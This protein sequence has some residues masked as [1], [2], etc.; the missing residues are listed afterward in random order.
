MCLPL[1]WRVLSSEWAPG[2]DLVLWKNA[3]G[4]KDQHREGNTRKILSVYATDCCSNFGCHFHLSA[5][6]K[7]TAMAGDRGWQSGTLQ[8]EL[9]VQFLDDSKCS[10]LRQHLH[11][12]HSSR[13]NWFHTFRGFNISR[14][15]LV[16]P[17]EKGI[18]L[19]SDTG[20]CFNSCEI[21]HCLFPGARRL[22]HKRSKVKK[23][24]FLTNHFKTNR[25]FRVSKMLES[26][27]FM[28]IVPPYRFTVYAIGILLGYFLHLFKNRTLSD[29][30]LKLGWIAALGSL[31]ITIAICFRNITYTP[32]NDA[33]FAGIGSVT[34]CMF[35]SWV[36]FVARLGHKSMRVQWLSPS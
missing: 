9:V 7:W 20:N 8:G 27:N 16:P 23:L 26:A 18:L 1:H 30:Q 32:F 31:V 34:I 14:H 28:Y 3:E 22:H 21:L 2:D 29:L 19:G 4:A 13:C 35:Y 24:S 6:G 36:I 17:S 15:L 33:M 12:E 11:G 25:I 5:A 10:G